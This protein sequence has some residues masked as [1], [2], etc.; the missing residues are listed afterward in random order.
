MRDLPLPTFPIA[1]LDSPWRPGMRLGVTIHDTLATS[2]W[3]S[4]RLA[5]TKAFTAHRGSDTPPA[6]PGWER[7]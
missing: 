1:G 4:L 5:V 7:A 6:P 3:V 2:L